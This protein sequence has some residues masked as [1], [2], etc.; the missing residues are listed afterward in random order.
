MIFKV[1]LLHVNY[2]YQVVY[3]YNAQDLA[4]LIMNLADD[5]IVSEIT[6]IKTTDFEEVVT[7]EKVIKKESKMEYGK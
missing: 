2:G 3:C 5:Y 1:K 6:S 4:K 7:I